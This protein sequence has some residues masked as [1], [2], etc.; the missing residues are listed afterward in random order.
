MSEN[1]RSQSSQLAEPLWTDPGI[2]SGISVREVISIKNKTKQT[3][4][5]TS[6]N[7]QAGNEWSNVLPKILAN[8]KQATTTIVTCRDSDTKG[9]GTQWA[10]DT[11]GPVTYRV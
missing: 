6:K 7:A 8:E 3:N 5:Q 11:S 4:K 2:K 9:N 10:C 1:T